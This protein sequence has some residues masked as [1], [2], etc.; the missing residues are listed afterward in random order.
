MR[1]AVAAEP[2]VRDPVR[3]VRT[4]ACLALVAAAASRFAGRT[5]GE[6]EFDVWWMLVVGRLA[7]LHATFADPLSFTAPGVVHHNH[8]WMHCAVLAAVERVAG[9]DGVWALK[10]TLAGGLTLGVVAFL[11]AR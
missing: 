3:T 10:V 2:P 7:G 4:L 1:G 5:I 11:R 6:F 9:L 8:T